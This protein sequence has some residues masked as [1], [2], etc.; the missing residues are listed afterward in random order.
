MTF[1]ILKLISYSETMKLMIIGLGGFLG[2]IMRYSLSGLAQNYAIK[3]SSTLFPVGTLFVNIVGCLLLGFFSSLLLERQVN[4]DYRFL[5][6][7]GFL[8]AFTTFSTFSL[9]TLQLIE[10]KQYLQGLLNILIS[11]IIGLYAIWQGKALYKL[12]W[13]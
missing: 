11:C 12:I 7:I 2:A 9:E 3:V 4:P 10:N 8:G 1:S 5:I 13:G 6:N